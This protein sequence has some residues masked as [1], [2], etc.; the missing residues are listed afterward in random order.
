MFSELPYH[1]EAQQTHRLRKVS[2]LRFVRGL[3]TRSSE[4]GRRVAISSTLHPQTC[5]TWTISD[6]RTPVFEKVC[7]RK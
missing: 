1:R 4:P 5:L 2:S 6:G 3:G 7:C